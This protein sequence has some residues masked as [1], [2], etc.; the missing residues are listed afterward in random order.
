[1]KHLSVFWRLAAIIGI[2]AVAFCAVSV[3]EIMSLRQTILAERQEKLRDMVGSVLKMVGT[4]D[5]DVAAGRLTTEQAQDLAKRAL[6]SMRWGDGDYYGVYRFDGV[7]LV[8]S[9][10]RNEGVNRM[11]YTDSSGRRLVHDMIGIARQGSGFTEYAV[12]R[13]GGTEAL[14]KLSYVGGYAPWQWAI[15]AGVYVDDVDAA[16]RKRAVDLAGTGLVALVLTGVGAVLLGRG[17]TRP[18]SALCGTLDRLAHGDRTAPV[19]FTDHH[20]EIGRIAR[21]VEVLKTSAQEADRLRGEQEDAKR[22]AV[23]RQREEMERVAREFEASVGAISRTLSAAASEMQDTAQAMSL[24]SGSASEQA[25]AVAAAATQATTN[26]Q[27]VASASEELT[28]SIGEIGQQVARS[29]Q[30]AGKAVEETRRTDATVEEL[31]AAAG[32]IG[33]II[34]LIQSI[35]SQT[36]LL[37]LNA[38][39]EAARAGVH[40]KGF[41]VVA[42]EVKALARQASQASG[43][44][45]QRIAAVQGISKDVVGA[46]RGIGGTIAELNGIASTIASA[47]E[48]QAA[49][50][51]EIARNVSQ[52]AQGTGEVSANIA[53][54]TQSSARVGDAAGSVLAAAR[55]L[56]QQSDRLQ[57]EVDGFLA[58]IRR[59]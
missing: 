17:I 53:G 1:M 33:E 39:I 27:T 22:Q 42:N 38:T 36:D 40:G 6:R 21:A 32:K 37:A 49:A 31:S 7:T 11:D 15:Q 55:T 56:A 51:H 24:T 4:Y 43:D 47:V 18:L 5:E 3:G 35:A 19:P 46:I 25:T 48:E 57:G 12:P 2:S 58:S 23:E 14:P 9:N 8:H 30:I 52:A 16:V 29:A 10:P 45:A 28:A 20:N 59:G 54:V 44:I 26:V 13:S 41:A 34:G 50:T